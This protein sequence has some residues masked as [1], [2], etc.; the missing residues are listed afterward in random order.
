[1]ICNR[2]IQHKE[3]FFLQSSDTTEHNRMDPGQ[4]PLG[5]KDE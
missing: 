2:R 3:E 4:V 5:H 1:M